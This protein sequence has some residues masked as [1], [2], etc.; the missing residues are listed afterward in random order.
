MP[1]AAARGRRRGAGIGAISEGVMA[2]PCTVILTLTYRI[3][4]ILPEPVLP[5]RWS[6]RPPV[7]RLGLTLNPQ[8]GR[9]LATYMANSG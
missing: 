8:P 5:P 9:V 6:Q 1:L 4:A 7:D 3:W 2:A